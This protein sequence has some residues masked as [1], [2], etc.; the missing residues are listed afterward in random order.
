MT[1]MEGLLESSSD[2]VKGTIVDNHVI[3]DILDEEVHYW[4]PQLNFRIETDE[5]DAD[6]TIVAGLIG[7]RPAVWTMFMFIYFFVGTVGFFI[8]S[9]GIFPHCVCDN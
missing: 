9:Y 1:R 4:S 5:L 3:L 7:P 6:S 8:S 2:K